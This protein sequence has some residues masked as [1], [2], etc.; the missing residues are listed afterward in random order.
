MPWMEVG[1]AV[2]VF[3]SVVALALGVPALR[4]LPLLRDRIAHYDS[5]A[6]TKQLDI[7]GGWPAGMEIAGAFVGV[8]SPIL[9][10]GNPVIGVALGIAGA[11]APGMWVQR[12]V[13]Q[14]ED[15]LSEQVPEVLRALANA[16]KA[17]LALP[18]AFREAS[19]R[20]RQPAAQEFGRLVREYQAGLSLAQAIQRARRRVAI[21]SFDLAMSAILVNQERGGNITETLESLATTMVELQEVEEHIETTTAQGRKSARVMIVV[22]FAALAMLYVANPEVVMVLFEEFA[23]QL[24]LLFA[25]LLIAAA[26]FWI[27]SIIRIDV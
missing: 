5:I 12:M 11:V 4:D 15:A 1:L 18:E 14:R 8:T 25:S 7:Q 26:Y 23:G 19:S 21:P 17:G 3:A 6:E 13:Q 24:I 27:R 20:A 2:C 10:F 22:P 9:L 16:V